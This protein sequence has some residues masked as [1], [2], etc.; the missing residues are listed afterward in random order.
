MAF[1][2]LAED[3]GPSFSEEQV[4]TLAAEFPRQVQDGP[5]ETGEMFDRPAKA[6]DRMP[7]PFPNE[8]AARAA[9]G[10]AYPP[11]LTVMAKAREG[12]PAHVYSLLL[13]YE[14]PPADVELRPGQYYNV[15]FPGHAIGMPPPMSDGQVTYDDDAPETLE[16]YARDVSAFLMWTAEPKLEERHRMG[17]Q[18]MIFLLIFAGLMYFSYKKLWRD[19]EH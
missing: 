18:V 14:E 13:G 1:R 2:N 12:G 11:D 15:S 19:V 5:D 17:F 6:S 3:G 7:P 8:A 9:N 4:D 10:G 16:Q